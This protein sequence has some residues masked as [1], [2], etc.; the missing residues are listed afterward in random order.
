MKKLEGLS[1]WKVRIRHENTAPHA[2]VLIERLATPG[3]YFPKAIVQENVEAKEMPI[4]SP[5][6]SVFRFCIRSR[7]EV[8]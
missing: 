4:S 3:N 6:L 8:R 2:I 5:L 7:R 1:S